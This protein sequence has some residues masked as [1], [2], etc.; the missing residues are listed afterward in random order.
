MEESTRAVLD[1]LRDGHT[2]IQASLTTITG[3]LGDFREFKGLVLGNLQ[4]I[5]LNFER[6]NGKVGRHDVDI[7][8]IQVA[9]AA[10]DRMQTG[11]YPAPV[12]FREGRSSEG[13]KPEAAPTKTVYFT[14]ETVKVILITIIIALALQ[15][16]LFPLLRHFKVPGFIPDPPAIE[17]KHKP[18]AE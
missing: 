1:N 4:S 13:E 15:G 2:A 17:E 3:Q 16:L 12:A 8:E 14:P 11:Q 7:K 18:A 6:L 5:D 9:G 10:R